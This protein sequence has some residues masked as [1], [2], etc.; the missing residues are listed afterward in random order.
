MLECGS[1]LRELSGIIDTSY[2]VNDDYD[3]CV[4]NVTVRPGKTVL[5]KFL[6]IRLISYD[7]CV[8]SYV[9]VRLYLKPC[10][11]YISFINRT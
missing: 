6:T 3:I 4:W 10:L 9:L 7:P 1:S 11:M 5:V 8:D 2:I